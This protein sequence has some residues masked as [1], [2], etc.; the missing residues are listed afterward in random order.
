MTAV[1][2]PPSWKRFLTQAQLVQ[3][4]YGLISIIPMPYVCGF[5]YFSWTYETLVFWFQEF[6]LVTFFI[7]FMAFYNK[8]YEKATSESKAKKH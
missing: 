7:L 8:R 2:L 5:G 6:V 1:G 3:F 4:L